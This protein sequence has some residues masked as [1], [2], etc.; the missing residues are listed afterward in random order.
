ME[1]LWT[2]SSVKK[3]KPKSFCSQILKL[4]FNSNLTYSYATNHQRVIPI[5]F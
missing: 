4:L 3:K 5:H 2:G 1:L